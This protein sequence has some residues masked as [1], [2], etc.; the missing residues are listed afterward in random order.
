MNIAFIAAIIVFVAGTGVALQAPMI[1]VLSS[2]LGPLESV[3]VVHIGGAILSGIPLAL[4]AGGKLGALGSMPWYT[5]FAGALG[6]ITIASIGFAVPR[7]G[8]AGASVA[9]ILGQLLVAALI[10][11]FGWFGVRVRALDLVRVAGFVLLLAGAWLVIR[12]AS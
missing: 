6:V 12:P 1:G 9:L 11:H 5:W 8:V 4:L 10:D 2:R 7:I 3:F